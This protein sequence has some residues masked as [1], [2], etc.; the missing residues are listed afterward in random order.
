MRRSLNIF[1]SVLVMLILLWLALRQVELDELLE[2]LFTVNI[3][4]VIPFTIV[5]AISHYLRAERWRLL[6]PDYEP[7][8][9]TLFAGVMLGYMANY[10]LPRLGEISRPV[11]V[12]RQEERSSGEMFGTIVL[13]RMVDLISLVSIL[14]VI[15]IFYIGDQST[16]IRL[17]GSDQWG[18]M[19]TL[20]LIALLVASV[21]FW[22]FVRW[23]RSLERRQVV[24][25]PMLLWLIRFMDHIWEG[26]R[27]I[28]SVRSW[29]LF[30]L[31]SAGIWLGYIIMSWL[32]FHMLDLHVH[33]DLGLT[34]AMVITVI[35][36]VGITIPTP[37]GAGSYHLL[38]QQGLW[39]LYAVP[40]STGLIYATVTHAV[41]LLA[42]VLV[43]TIALWYDKTYAL[44]AG[45]VR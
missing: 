8:R 28:R 14:L 17:M 27:S 19:L 42:V 37:G 34:E 45:R 5:L 10:V 3:G 18:L 33:F 36:A 22:L 6:I 20:L 32:P 13:E 1:L 30:F 40:L 7:S 12:A 24:K 4:W 26:L 15:I 38:V 31:H 21:L 43:G 41:T 9:P 25:H 44:N 11:Y 23:L 2:Q 29:P 16:M 35:A 39:V